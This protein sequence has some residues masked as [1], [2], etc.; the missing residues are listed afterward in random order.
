MGLHGEEDR[1]LSPDL[2]RANVQS[3]LLLQICRPDLKNNVYNIISRLRA[4]DIQNEKY[5][6][7]SNI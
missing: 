2:L 7:L 4:Y 1:V 3:I 5:Q 6:R